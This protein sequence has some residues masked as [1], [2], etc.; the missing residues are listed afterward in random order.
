MHLIAKF[1][2][3]TV[4]L[5][6]SLRFGKITYLTFYGTHMY[7]QIFMRQRKPLSVSL[8]YKYFISSSLL[9]NIPPSFPNLTRTAL[10]LIMVYF[11]VAWQRLCIYFAALKRSTAA[12]AAVSD[13]FL[14]LILYIVFRASEK[15]Y[16]NRQQS[17]SN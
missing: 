17:K 11:D 13:N 5:H 7:T 3:F 15:A 10:H 8:K 9:S 14:R 6:R 12:L 2:K 16:H 1:K 4:Y